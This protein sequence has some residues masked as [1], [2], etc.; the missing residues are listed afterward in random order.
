MGPS[1]RRRRDG[2]DVTI[3]WLADRGFRVVNV[4][5]QNPRGCDCA[6][7]SWGHAVGQVTGTLVDSMTANDEDSNVEVRNAF[8]SELPG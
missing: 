5:D 2:H 3:A 1:V 7:L 8:T 4:G 6:Y